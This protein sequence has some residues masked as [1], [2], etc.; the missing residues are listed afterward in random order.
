M[1]VVGVVE[2]NDWQSSNYIYCTIYDAFRAS[3][4]SSNLSCTGFRR[5]RNLHS[6][7][8]KAESIGIRNEMRETNEKNL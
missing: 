2:V 6:L 3:L 1:V 5:Y 7:R 8:L 4:R